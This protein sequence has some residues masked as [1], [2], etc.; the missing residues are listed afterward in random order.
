MTRRILL[1]V[2]VLLIAAL[3]A[4]ALLT[5]LYWWRLTAP[6]PTDAPTVMLI[7][8]GATVPEIARDLDQQGVID[9]PALFRLAVRVRQAGRALRAGE[10]EIPAGAGLFAVVDTLTTADPIQ[11]RLTVPEGLTSLEIVR[12][13][14]EAPRLVGDIDTVPDEGRLLPETYFY[15]AGE[16]RAALVHRMK[17]A[18]DE[19][20]TQAWAQRADNLAIDTPDQAVILASIVEKETGLASERRRVAA[21]FHNRL[22][23][24]MRLQSDPTVIYAVA[25]GE[26]LERALTRQDLDVDDA[27]N[28]YRTRGLPPGPIANPGKAALI[29]AVNPADSADLYFV[30]DGSG[31]HAFAR[32]LEQHNANVARWR[33]HQRKQAQG[34]P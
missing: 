31:G 19:A 28:T 14:R 25:G 4:G 1:T 7:E 23:R 6:G 5:G 9:S 27:Y 16:T 13:I 24:G 22:R 29:A 34:D 17:A 21:V 33:R 18:M 20:V 30:A 32:T 8:R 26:G 12:L 11:R 10:Y 3:V 2:S 15:V